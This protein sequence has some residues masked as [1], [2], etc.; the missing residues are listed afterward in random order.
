MA[1][2]NKFY[3]FPEDIGF[4]IGTRGST[5]NNIKTT[6]GSHVQ[7]YKP[8][9]MGGVGEGDRPYFLIQ[10]DSQDKISHAWE[11]LESIAQ[12]SYNRRHGMF[13]D[14]CPLEKRFVPTPKPNVSFTP[15]PVQVQRDNFRYK[16]SPCMCVITLPPNTLGEH[17]PKKK[18]A[19]YI[20]NVCNRCHKQFTQ[21]EH[22]SKDHPITPMNYNSP[23]KQ[24][25]LV[26]EFSDND[27]DEDEDY[28]FITIQIKKEENNTYI[29]K[30]DF[31]EFLVQEDGDIHGI[32]MNIDGKQRRAVFIE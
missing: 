29:G 22:V 5:I 26:I 6:S 16:I 23:P 4:V 14:S 7:I 17:I 2:S 15:D 27:S 25:R 3:I 19:E 24:D 12:E 32:V 18:L 31:K 8:K 30:I 11:L 28:K 21:A 20:G 9:S 10:G 1:Y 13:H